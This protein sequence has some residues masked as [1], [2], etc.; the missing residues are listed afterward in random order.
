VVRDS[1]VSGG[2][3]S[4][5]AVPGRFRIAIVTWIERTTT[6]V[7]ATPH[8]VC[9]PRSNSTPSWPCR[10]VRPPSGHHHVSVQ[11]TQPLSPRSVGESTAIR[12]ALMTRSFD[13]AP[14]VANYVGR[15]DRL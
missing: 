8:S 10:P 3:A 7:G 14:G 4:Q 11:Q 1:A 13:S 2:P 12:Q 9:R 6:T 5:F 15:C